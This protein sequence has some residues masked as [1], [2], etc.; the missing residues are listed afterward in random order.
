MPASQTNS[1]PRPLL[2]KDL[3]K[4]GIIC[5][6]GKE[7]NAIQS[8]FDHF[9]LEPEERPKTVRGDGNSYNFGTICGHHV[10]LAG[11]GGTENV[12]ATD[13]AKDME[14]S[15]Q[16]IE[17]CLVVGIC[18]IIPK[19]Q[20]KEIILGDV[21]MSKEVIYYT[22]GKHYPTGHRT[23][24]MLAKAPKAITRGFEQLCSHRPWKAFCDKVHKNLRNLM[25]DDSIKELNYKHP[26]RDTDFLYH[27]DYLHIHRN[28]DCGDC[29]RERYCQEAVDASCHD[30][31]CSEEQLVRR[32]RVSTIARATAGAMADGSALPD[33]DRSAVL[34]IDS[35]ILPQILVG[36]M[37]S[38]DVVLKDGTV[39]DKF[40]RKSDVMAFEMEGAGVSFTFPTVIIKA[41]CDYADSHKKK[42][43]QE[44][45]AMTAASC[46]KAFLGQLQ[47]GIATNVVYVS[48]GIG[49]ALEPISHIPLNPE[50]TY[51]Q[52]VRRRVKYFRGRR[53]QLTQIQEYF[54]TDV[55][56]HTMDESRVLILQAMGGQGKSQIALEY[57]RQSRSRYAEIFWV[58]ASSETMA[59]QS[60]ER[61]AAEIGQPLMGIDDART[62]TRLVVHT[63]ARR[64]ERWLMVLDNYDD[65]DHFAT[66][67]RFIPSYG[68]GDILITTRSRG[69]ESLGQVLTVPPMTQQEGTELLLRDH[70]TSEVDT[71]QEKCYQ[72]VR[73]LGG[74]PLALDQA[75]A[76]IRYKQLASN[77]LDEFLSLYDAQREEVLRHTPRR[78]WKYGTVQIDGKEEENR[79]ISAFTTWE[80]SFRQWEE[81]EGR[82]GDIEHFLT[83]SAFLQPDQINE[84]LFRHYCES[85]QEA[86]AWMRIFSQE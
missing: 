57:C 75:A 36:K 69:L 2:N 66:I 25:E 72:I 32:E 13:V 21:V 67:D 63:L 70:P 3:Y 48:E 8:S 34:N 61:V 5:A 59:V 27:A 79:A 44:W 1:K 58:N 24:D 76:F 86:P 60:L 29:R 28:G 52:A 84:S 83:V 49:K 33:G 23:D 77:Q 43:W 46:A 41:G 74:L 26:G 22:K 54:E 80:M 35:S 42:H 30:I 10:V 51:E 16:H 81:D 64:N 53:E 85:T 68:L 65:P 40:A 31:G 78:F 6:L 9:F 45:A 12:Q 17:L 39:R 20:E 37:A 55:T 71:H 50:S 19:Y 82:R 4:V 62:R 73:R 11:I 47:M 15:F 7:T 56:D 38:G 14:R 18:G